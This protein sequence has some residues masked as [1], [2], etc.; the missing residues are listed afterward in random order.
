MIGYWQVLQNQAL[1]RKKAAGRANEK[2]HAGMWPHMALVSL[3]GFIGG[4][5]A[6]VARAES[7]PIIADV[8]VWFHSEFP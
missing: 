6:D 3:A 2:S 7:I 1:F 5:T 8:P 4:A